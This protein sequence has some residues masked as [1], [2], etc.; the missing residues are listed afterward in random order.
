[1]ANLINAII[2]L[3]NAPAHELM[4]YARANNRANAM[5]DALEEY[6][7]DIFA[8]TVG[9]KDN[10]QRK[11]ILSKRFSYLGNTHNPPDAILMGGDAIEVK[12]IETPDAAIALNSSYP[13][14]KLHVDNPMIS[15][16]CKTC[17]DW[18]EKDIIYTVGV[19]R[20]NNLTSMAMVYGTEYCAASEVYERVRTHIKAGVNDIPGV[21]FAYT[22]ELGRVNQVDP[23]GITY[24]R[25]RG[26]WGIENPFIVFRDIYTRD[27][28][29]SFNFMAIVNTDKYN[30]FENKDE[31]ESLSFINPELLIED[32]QVHDP[33]NPARLIDVKLITYRVQ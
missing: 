24:L 20:D 4:E 15:K 8:G 18:Q 13:K 19:V 17:E 16:A 14:D 32:K 26:M 12:K 23:L 28:S 6:V 9:L 2:N 5:G 7:K 33:N 3:V 25:I 10:T 27:F 29:N 21:E 22:K 30:S 1:M 31:L 11:Q